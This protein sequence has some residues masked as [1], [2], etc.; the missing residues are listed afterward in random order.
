MALVDSGSPHGALPPWLGAEAVARWPP[1]AGTGACLRPG[2]SGPVSYS[3]RPAGAEARPGPRALPPPLDFGPGQRAAAPGPADPE[4]TP[5]GLTLAAA[6]PPATL[7][8]A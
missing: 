8:R 5:S 1:R 2:G 3:R 6:Q 7:R 4:L